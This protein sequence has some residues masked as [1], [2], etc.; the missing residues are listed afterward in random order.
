MII[1][2]CYGIKFADSVELHFGG[3]I[4]EHRKVKPSETELEV[5]I[6]LIE[7][8][9]ANG[10]YNHWLKLNRLIEGSKEPLSKLATEE[11]YLEYLKSYYARALKELE[12]ILIDTPL[13]EMFGKEK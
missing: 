8:Y 3:K 10:G 6:K 1:Y 4:V 11:S 7:H 12:K 5:A 13:N 9:K 2:K